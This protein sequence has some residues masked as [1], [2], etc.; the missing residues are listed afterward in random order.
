[1]SERDDDNE[2]ARPLTKDQQ[3]LAQFTVDVLKDAGSR[4]VHADRRTEQLLA[5]PLN[6]S[7]FV[8]VMRA[9]N[10]LHHAMVNHKTDKAAT[11]ANEVWRA[12]LKLASAAA[13]VAARGDANWPYDPE[14]TSHG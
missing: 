13:I 6:Q 10:A 2:A 5:V 8:E 11:P 4:A 3:R 7:T 9:Y 1:M 12:C 14:E